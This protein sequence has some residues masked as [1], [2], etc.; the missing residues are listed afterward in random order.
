MNILFIG[1]P[2]SG[3]G[4]QAQKLVFKKNL[5]HLS[6]G[7]LF[8][9]NL[10]EKT[11]LG[12]LAKSYIDKGE[13]VP[14]QITNGMVE[15][16]LKEV[17]EGEGVLF[18]GFPRNLSQAEALD[19]SLKKTDRKLNRVIF[20]DVPD[21]V[22]VERLTGRL[23][24]PESGCVYHIKNKPPKRAG[25]CDKSGETLVTREDDREELIR[26]RLKVFHESTKPLLNDYRKKGILR[27]IQAEASPEEV[28]N[29][30]LKA[31]EES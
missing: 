10:K 20:L 27:I 18:D 26:S 25:F 4:T 6:T 21:D 24:A 17:S 12:E 3:K 13:L 23:W 2:G 19:Q 15:I 16:F 8:R 31:I 1:P 29:Q 11:S 14:D 30:I 9:K 22:I 5:K 28:F 7:D